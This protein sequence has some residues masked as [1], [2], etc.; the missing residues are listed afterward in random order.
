MLISKKIKLEVSEQD[1]AILEWMQD[2]CRGLYNWWVMKLRDG[3]KWPGW[4]AAKRTLQASKEHD[5]ELRW[6]YGKLLHEV[7]FR[8]DGAMKAF[9]RRVKNDEKPGFPRVR[10]R[11]CFFTLIYPAMYIK[12]EG[13]SITLPTGGKGKNK[14]FPD[15]VA[16][17]TEYAPANYRDV[18]ISRDGQGHYYASFVHKEKEETHEHNGVLAI[19]LGVKTLATG[20]NEQGR[21]YHI[22]GFK[23]NRWYNRQLDKIC[24]KRDR[25]KKGSR[26]YKHLS[27][28][29]K[30]V[31]Q[32]KRNKQHDSLHKASHLIA[33]K[34]VERTVVV[35]DLSQRQMVM[36]EHRERNKHLNRAVFND[37]GLYTFIQMLIYKCHLYGKDLQF[38]DERNTSKACSGC[39]NLKAMPLW[40]RTYHCAECGLVMDRDDN[41]AVNILMRF[42]ARLGPHTGDPVRC[43][44]V[45][46]AI[47][48]V[49]NTFDYI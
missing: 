9:Y 19:D 49:L 35:G 44:D 33:H 8:L 41:S 1:A 38:L 40:K 17:L 25:C 37:W 15:I 46:T 5:P 43:A 28:V 14:L 27:H 21:F 24:S 2:K 6:V 48:D 29:Y 32:Q 7:Y 34:L 22:G 30:R 36:K 42:L 39:G 23:G 3:E 10:P 13:R 45:F 20:V 16:K 26:R 11:H 18:A 4:E 47:E 31:S 12:I